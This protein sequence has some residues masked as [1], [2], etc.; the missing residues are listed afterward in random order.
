[1]LLLVV[2]VVQFWEFSAEFSV[3]SFQKLMMLV[4]RRVG[5]GGAQERKRGRKRQ[6]ERG[7][8]KKTEKETVVAIATTSH[9]FLLFIIKHHTRV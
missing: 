9:C 3:Q 8:E 7:E 1:M 5:W 6:K 4:D 2:V